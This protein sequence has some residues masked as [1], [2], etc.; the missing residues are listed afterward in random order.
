MGFTWI[1]SG[2][3]AQGPPGPG[4][5]PGGNTGDHLAKRS[6]LDNDTEWVPPPVTGIGDAPID[7]VTYGRNTGAWVAVPDVGDLTAYVEI[8]GDTMTGPLVLPADPAQPL[9]AATKQY[10]DSRVVPGGIPEAPIDGTTYG[11]NNAS[12]QRV[13]TSTDLDGKVDV[14]GDVMTGFLTLAGDPTQAMHAATRQYV[15]SR[16]TPITDAPIDGNLYGRINAAWGL[17][18]S[19]SDLTNYVEIVGDTMTGPLTLPGAPTQ[20]LHAATKQYV[21]S[22]V[23]GG[24]PDAPANNVLY[25]RKNNAWS[26]A[27]EQTDLDRYVEIAGD[28]MTGRLTLSDD[29]TANLHAATKQYVDRL[30]AG[31]LLFIGTIDAATGTCDFTVSSGIPDGPLPPANVH[32]NEF[33]ICTV[34]GTIPS[35]PAAGIVLAPGDWLLSDGVNWNKVAAGGAATVASQVACI[36]AV[37]GANNVQDALEQAET[38]VDAK[39]AKAGDTMTGPLTLPGDPTLPLHA[40]TKDYV[41]T[42][43]AGGTADQIPLNPAIPPWTNVQEGI[44]GL[45]DTKVALAGDTMTGRLTLSADPIAPLHAATKN[46]VDTRPPFDATQIPLNPSLPPIDTVQEALNDLYANKLDQNTA[47]GLYV[48]ITG[49]AMTG[50][51][52]APSVQ[53]GGGNSL[54][55]FQARWDGV[56]TVL[57]FWTRRYNSAYQI[58]LELAGSDL[59]TI[60]GQMYTNEFNSLVD[61][62]GLTLVGGG[63]FYKRNGGGVVIRESSGGQQ[64]QI[65]NNDGTGARDILDTALG[66]LRYGTGAWTACALVGGVSGYC[67]VRTEVGGT[68]A[69]LYYKINR[70][71]ANVGNSQF[72]T[73]PAGFAPLNGQASWGGSNKGTQDGG[74]HIGNAEGAAVSIIAQGATQ[75]AYGETTW[76]IA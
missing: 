55:K 59:R 54:P 58:N 4:V 52:I 60:N 15:D 43:T 21:D 48:N 65:E 28:T 8:A 68:V 45:Q 23:G 20:P 3:G 9:E 17:A 49:D 6:N 40:A 75:D 56:A 29:P 73:L 71:G 2:A 64:P 1:G 66:D 37:F 62:G 51:L 32:L 14:A 27:V 34:G 7:G 53:I 13:A 74:W 22:A 76:R 16:I 44:Q 69:R 10:V 57:E 11:R 41:D 70:A 63:R 46:Y 47:D 38:E 67:W 61:G 33:V 50:G 5:A 72:A 26:P 36:P 18:A 35:G 42:Q 12:W 24:I 30:V 19:Q 25:G 31:T 39:V